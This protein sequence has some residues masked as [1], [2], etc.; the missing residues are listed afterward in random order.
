VV[1]FGSVFT[2]FLTYGLFKLWLQVQLP[3]G[4]WGM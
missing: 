2:S 3:V 4:L 1:V